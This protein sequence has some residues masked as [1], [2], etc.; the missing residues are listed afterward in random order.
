M[1]IGVVADATCDLPHEYIQK[2]R[3]HILPIGIRLGEELMLDERDPE[4]TARFYSEHLD[5]KGLDAETVPPTPEQIRQRFLDRIVLEH[6]YVLVI[7]VTSTRSPIFEHAT[8]AS[9]QILND[10][11]APRAKAGI[12]VPFSMR[13]MDSQTLF[14][15]SAVLAA[16]AVKLAAQQRTPNDMRKRLEEVRDNICAYMVPGDLFYIRNRGMKKGEKSVG[17]LTYAIGTALDI[18]PVIQAYHG[19]TQPV[20]KVRHYGNAVEKMLKHVERQIEEGLIAKHVCLSYGGDLAEVPKLPG[21]A[22]LSH[23]ARGAGVDLLLATMSATAAVNAGAG[24]LAVAYSAELR[25]FAG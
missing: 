6:D 21:Y 18:K 5:A 19:E 23:K 14:S 10:Y 20:A 13:V 7:T 11:K 4:A 3:I 22:A 12:N 16:E 15:G 2:H 17:L 1:R 25:D 9:F 8:K 24:C